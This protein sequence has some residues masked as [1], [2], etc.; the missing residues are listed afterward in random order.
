MKDIPKILY[1]YCSTESFYG[2]ITSKT[3]WLSNSIYSNDPNENKISTD[4]LKDIS[5][6]SKDKGIGIFAKKV[7]DFKFKLIDDSAAYVFCMTEREEDLN[8]WRIYGDNGYGY[9]I[10]INTEYFINNKLWTFL[11]YNAGLPK[12]DKIYLAKC[13]YDNKAQSSLVTSL[14]KAV[15]NLT[16]INDEDKI[17]LTKQ[18][19]QLFS[20]IFKHK[21]YIEENEWR[22]ICFPISQPQGN[23]FKVK[24][25]INFKV[26]RGL[27]TQYIKQEYMSYATFE[28]P[29]FKTITL[30]SNVVNDG[31]EIMNFIHF[32]GGNYVHQIPISNLK[33]RDKKP[34]A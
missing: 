34:C 14:L 2:I 13:I 15:K 26:S 33:I 3:I 4:I 27:I 21:S 18:Y 11:D 16:Q 17:I 10:G 12:M 23:D 29:P 19:L 25:D 31:F 8:Q 5:L 1:H 7:L 22:L 6:N 9:M 30:G 32:Q 28:K 20:S 24:F